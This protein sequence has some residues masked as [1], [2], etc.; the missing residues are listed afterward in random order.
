MADDVKVLMDREYSYE[1]GPSLKRTLPPGKAYFVPLDIADDIEER[2]FGRRVKA[3]ADDGDDKTGR[4]SSAT[5]RLT[6]EGQLDDAAA[7]TLT[8]G[9]VKAEIDVPPG[10]AAMI[11]DDLAAAIED[12]DLGLHARID[13]K[14]PEVII[15]RAPEPG[16]AGNDLTLA[17]SPEI[18]NLTLTVDAF[19]GGSDGD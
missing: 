4:R 6:V 16:A 1:P 18:D 13:A 12:S 8:L 15:L 9:D 14:S 11:A 17:I 5:A 10:D 7:V 3:P 19:A 2:S